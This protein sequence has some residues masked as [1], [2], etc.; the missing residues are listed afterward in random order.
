MADELI[1]KVT[2]MDCDGCVKAVTRAATG[3]G[4]APLSVDLKSGEMRLPG[5]A[6]VPA[7]T[8]A[9]QRAGAAGQFLGGLAAHLQ[10]HQEGAHLGRGGVA[11]GH[12]VEGALGF[13]DGKRLAVAHLGQKTA[14]IVDVAAHQNP[15]TFCPLPAGPAGA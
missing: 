12:D 14:K 6:D 1:L 9:I 11:R 15:V 2:G 8:K 4:T 3:A 13:T 10:A 7:I 5:D